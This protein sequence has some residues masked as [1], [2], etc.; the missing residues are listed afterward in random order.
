MSALASP[1]GFS[2]SRLACP[3]GA[4]GPSAVGRAGSSALVGDRRRV[5]ARGM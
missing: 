4:T 2:V 1:T 5:R 3:A